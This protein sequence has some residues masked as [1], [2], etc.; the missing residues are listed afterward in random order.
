MHPAV[1][2]NPTLWKLLAILDS[3]NRWLDH[4]DSR[5][6]FNEI[7]DFISELEVKIDELTQTTQFLERCLHATAI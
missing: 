6:S 3:A 7:E 2:A 4:C 1:P 5:E